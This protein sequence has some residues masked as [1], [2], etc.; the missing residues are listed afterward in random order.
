MHDAESILKAFQRATKVAE[1]LRN[2][3]SAP[4]STVW[5]AVLRR[6]YQGGVPNSKA[7]S[8]LTA[9]ELQ[10]YQTTC[11]WASCIREEVYR[12]ILW[13]YASGVSAGQI[14]KACGPSITEA[15]IGLR[16]M[17]ALAFVGYKVDH[18]KTPPAFEDRP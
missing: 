1:R 8:G 16:I 5:P 18:G 11:A 13:A 12:R 15:D 17:W 6:D 3:K 10:E 4:V 14:A 2:V 9:T 7:P